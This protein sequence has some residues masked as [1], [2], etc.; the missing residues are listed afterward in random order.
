MNTSTRVIIVEDDQDLRESL[1]EFLNLAGHDVS[2][3]GSGLEFYQAIAASSFAIAVVDVGLP[4]QCG[5]VI[6]EYIRKNPA[7]GVIMLT[8]RDAIEDRVRGYDAGADLYMV[9]PVDSRELGA[10]ITS[11]KVN[12]AGLQKALA[13]NPILVTALNPRIGYL[14]AAAIAKRAY[15]EGRP[16]IDVAEEDSGLTRQELEALLDPARLTEGGLG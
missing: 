12:E 10:A 16:I 15:K 13:R 14:R 9:K 7:M 3:V 2:G 8:A 11:F 4:D 5:Y 6:T 1:V